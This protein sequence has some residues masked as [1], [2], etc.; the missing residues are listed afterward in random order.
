MDEG[1]R[2]KNQNQNTFNS[3]NKGKRQTQ[4]YNDLPLR[5][6]KLITRIAK[7]AGDHVSRSEIF[8]CAQRIMAI[9]EH[10]RE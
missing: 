8:S 5:A 7:V 10:E 3:Y 9:E 6:K 2:N 1:S 4:A